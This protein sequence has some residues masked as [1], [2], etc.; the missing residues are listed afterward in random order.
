MTSG[1][2]TTVT[3]RNRHG[4][5]GCDQRGQRLR[6][7]LQLRN[8]FRRFALLSY[9]TDGTDRPTGCYCSLCR[10]ND[11]SPMGRKM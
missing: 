5:G 9:A 10:V 8:Y 1:G 7:G 4:K 3:P 11:N 2:E 6:R